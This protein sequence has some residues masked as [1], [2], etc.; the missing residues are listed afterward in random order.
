MSRNIYN[1]KILKSMCVQKLKI[2]E[3]NLNFQ[4]DFSYSKPA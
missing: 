1:H 4:Q 2:S 3:R